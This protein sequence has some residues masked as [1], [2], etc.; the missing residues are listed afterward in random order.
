MMAATWR[1]LAMKD[2]EDAIRSRL[3]WGTVVVFVA[4]LVMSLLTAEELFPDAVVVDIPK[5]LSGVAMLGQLFIPG[6]ALLVGYLAVVGER[7]SGSLRVLLSYP[8]S[9]TEIIAGKLVARTVVTL[10]ALSI[11]LV[12]AF[13]LIIIR[14]G[15]PSLDHAAGFIAA[16]TLLAV[17]FTVFAVGGSAAVASRGRAM[18]VTV[19]SFVVMVFFWRPL[20]IGAYYIRYGSLPGVEV[21]AWYLLALRLNPLESYRVL[22]GSRLDERVYPLPDLHLEDVPQELPAA[23]FTTAIRLGGDVPVYLG[24]AFGAVVMAAWAVVPAYI[25][26]KRFRSADLS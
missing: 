16:S 14:Y 10:T 4:F 15:W 3:F 11:G 13:A 18:A 8:F 12:V 6:V 5:L 9:R 21:E 17:S 1:S 26:L 7:R 20:V 24:P 2:I 23:E 25:G 22:V 19:G